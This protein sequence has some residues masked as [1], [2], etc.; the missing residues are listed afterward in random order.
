M[1]A[2]FLDTAD[3][4]L[5][6]RSDMED[7]HWVHE[8]MTLNAT[9]PY[10][11]EKPIERGMR[12]LIL[13]PD[14]GGPEVF[15]IRSVQSIESDH[16]QQITAEH[17]VISELTDEHME[18]RELMNVSARNALSAVLAGTLWKV[19]NVTATGNS[20][21]KLSRGSVWQA[22]NS[23]RS[24][25]NVYIVPRITVGSEGITGRFLDILPAEGTWRGVRLSIDKNMTDPSV[26]Y[27]DSEMVTAMYGY[28]GSVSSGD[29]GDSAPLMFTSAAWSRTAAHPAKPKG[30]KYL[31]DP[32]ATRLYG[33]NG[34]PRY[35]YYQNAEIDNPTLL[36]EK[37]WEALQTV[38]HPKV[39]I[40]GTVTDLYRLGYAD[41][42]LRLHDT[43]MVDIEPIGVQMQL[44]II[45]MDTDLIDPT[46]TMVT[47]GSYIP[48][49]IYIA[50]DTE[51]SATGE[52]GSGNRYGGPGGGSKNDIVLDGFATEILKNNEQI[53]LR[54]YQYDVNNV[55]TILREAGILITKDKVETYAWKDRGTISSII[56]QT[57]ESLT[58]TFNN[59]HEE[60]RSQIK[61]EAGRI[62]LLVEG[63]GENAKIKPAAIVAEIDKYR[64]RSKVKLSAD[65]IDLD[66]IV[67]ALKTYVVRTGTLLTSNAT[68]DYTL[69]VNGAL[70]ALG[71]C[72]AKQF[73]V[74]PSAGVTYAM[75]VRDAQLSSDQTKLF[76]YK[77]DGSY[78][79][80]SKAVTSINWS[81][82]GGTIYA[83]P[84]PQGSP[85]FEYTLYPLSNCAN[86]LTFLAAPN[87][88]T[89]QP[90]TL[91]YLYNGTY[92]SL[93]TGYWY[94]RDSYMQ[95]STFYV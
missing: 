85:T 15:E 70:N 58:S 47:I 22:V 44:E 30:Q 10:V 95:T 27:D 24:D 21:A 86:N 23:I 34:R 1:D 38:N 56:T 51:H 63:T 71:G 40:E 37:T 5:F 43:A 31:E 80:F 81:R 14:S 64:K 82:S 12:V 52:S 41:Q 4:S 76:I 13:D 69:T 53:K 54:A 49:I 67:S 25:W 50:R 94:R 8:E 7:G 36:L 74:N 68:I 75:K 90:T 93:G 46:G 32:E 83:T 78:L 16:Y 26:T 73:V 9:F 77:V 91:Y 65:I 79:T 92:Y 88:L 20:S 2:L 87:R 17:I 35:G 28:G 45:Q 19:G 60:L 33:R 29:S 3:K 57:A 55:K 62:S 11:A 48:N 39:T 42:P 72:W 6:F 66:G 89:D 59:A 84:Q 18:E 61:Q